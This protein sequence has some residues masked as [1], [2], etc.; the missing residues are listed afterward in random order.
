MA[1][2]VGKFYDLHRGQNLAPAVA[3]REAQLWLRRVSA[4]DLREYVRVPLAEGKL[5]QELT[6]FLEQEVLRNSQMRGLETGDK[7]KASRETEPIFAHPYHWGGLML[8][9]L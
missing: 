5:P 2:L 9:G 8:T 3:L 4:S 1:L 6:E 7:S